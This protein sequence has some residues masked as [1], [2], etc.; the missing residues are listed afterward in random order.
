MNRVIIKIGFFI[1]SASI[2][3]ATL[4]LIIANPLTFGGYSLL[5]RACLLNLGILA[6]FSAL[7]PFFLSYL[8][9]DRKI[10]TLFILASSLP[11]F[12][13]FLLVLPSKATDEIY[14]D[15]LDSSF[16]SDRSS[17]GIIEIGFQYPIFTPTISLVNRDAF[18]RNVNIFLRIIESD[19]E[20]FLFRAVRSKAKADDEKLSVESTIRGM[21][22]NNL[23]YLFN[24]VRLAPGQALSGR[25]IFIITNFEDGASLAEALDSGHIGYLEL[26]DPDQG[27]L[28]ADFKLAPI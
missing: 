27:N 7:F 5:I 23:R 22:S 1:I 13:F 11:A 14:F 12:I 6:G 28:L 18:T 10:L 15:Q 16:L 24:P 25:P 2:S 19:Q 8:K 17:N 20:A 21:L 4:I 3:I 26:R 9:L